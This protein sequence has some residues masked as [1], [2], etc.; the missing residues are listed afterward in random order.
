[1]NHLTNDELGCFLA[2]YYKSIHGE[3]PT[4]EGIFN[5]RRDMLNMIRQLDKIRLLDNNVIIN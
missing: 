4:E 5:S 1:M 3:F 2:D